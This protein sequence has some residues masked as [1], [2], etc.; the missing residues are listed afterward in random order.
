[1]HGDA[2]AADTL[3][4]LLIVQRIAALFRCL[5]LGAAF[6]TAPAIQSGLRIIRRCLWNLGKFRCTPCAGTARV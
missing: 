5:C 4:G 6:L 2:D 1:M 3:F